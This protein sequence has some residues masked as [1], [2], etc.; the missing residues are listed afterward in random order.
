M[1]WSPI[2][3]RVVV[4]R[5]RAMVAELSGAELEP[6]AIVSAIAG[7]ASANRRYGH[8]PPHSPSTPQFSRPPVG[9]DHGNLPDPPAGHCAGFG[10][11][12]NWLLFPG[13]F[14][15][16]WRDG[17]L[18]GSLIDVLNR[19]APVAILAIGMTAVI[20]TKGVDLSVGAVMAISGAVAAV[21]VTSGQPAWLAVMAALAAELVSCGLER[22][23]CDR[24][25]NP[26]DHCHVGPDGGRARACAAGDRGHHRHLYQ[27]P[28]LIFIG[29]G[30]VLGLPTPV[31]IR[32][33]AD[34]SGHADRAAHRAWPADRGGAGVNR[35][36][37]AL[38][39]ISA[40]LLLV[41]AYTFAG[42][43]AATAG[44]IAAG[45]IR[46]ADANNAG[47]WLELDAILAVVIG[48]PH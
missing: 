30:S 25:A 45:D 41:L 7:T 38:A 26:A 47:L 8:D 12:V 9:Q 23:P 21:M 34:G 48:A 18:F 29:T 6:D 42:F 13:F 35:S 5:D 10:L 24:A 36:A 31:F 20:A 19:G 39:G 2:S 11:C 15:I 40:G 46:G 22:H 32:A 33:D 27:S 3:N 43:C 44:L 4:M 14:S 1:R 17:R 37:A 16:T 28:V